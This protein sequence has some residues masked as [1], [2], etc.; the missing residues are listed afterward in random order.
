MLVGAISG[1]ADCV[2]LLEGSEDKITELIRVRV[3]KVVIIVVMF[4]DLGEFI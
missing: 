1:R 4:F 3:I 2:W